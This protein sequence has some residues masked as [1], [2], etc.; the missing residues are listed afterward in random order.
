MQDQIAKRQAELTKPAMTTA[1][2]TRILGNAVSGLLEQAVKCDFRD[3]NDHSLLTNTAFVDAAAALNVATQYAADSMSNPHKYRDDFE[4]YAA[5]YNYM[6][7]KDG[8]HMDLRKSG[9]ADKSYKSDAT[10]IAYAVYVA[11]REAHDAHVAAQVAAAG[12]LQTLLPGASINDTHRVDWLLGALMGD[13][14]ADAD[15]RTQFMA[16][17]MLVGRKGR[18]AI[19]AARLMYE[20]AEAKKRQDGAP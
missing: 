14:S 9:R 10:E 12:A 18:D 3:S 17:A 11:G 4:N 16:A 13:D 2:I 20:E 7:R 15:R 1:Y 19:D 5:G 6:H 8:L